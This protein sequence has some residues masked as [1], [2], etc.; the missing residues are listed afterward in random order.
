MLNVMSNGRL[1]IHIEECLLAGFLKTN[2][3]VPHGRHFAE[4]TSTVLRD[5]QN[6]KKRSSMKR[7]IPP[8]VILKMKSPTCSAKN[9]TNTTY[10]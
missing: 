2:S 1:F 8:A 6:L 3:T 9:T 4:S 5:W 10:N 7:N